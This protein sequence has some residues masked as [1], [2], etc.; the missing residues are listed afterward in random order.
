[1]AWRLEYTKEAVRQLRKMGPADS[2]RIRD[3]MRK[4]IDGCDNPRVHGKGLTANLSGMWRYRIGDWRVLANIDDGVVVVEVFKI[5]HRS[6]VYKTK[7][8]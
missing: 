8:H 3:W 4:H 5:Q 2:K 6:G 1:M 7:R